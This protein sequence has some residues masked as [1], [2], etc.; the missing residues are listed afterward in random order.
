MPPATSSPQTRTT[1][2]ISTAPTTTR[3]SN[4]VVGADAANDVKD[5]TM[6][7]VDFGIELDNA[8]KITVIKN[9]VLNNKTGGVALFWTQTED[10]AIIDNQI[11]K[12]DGDGI[13]LCNC[14]SGGN[15]IYG[16]LI[17]TN[18]S[19]TTN[20]G[21]T[22]D[23]INIGTPN[24]TVGGTAAGGANV[25]AFN[26]GAGIGL[27]QLSTDTGNALVANSIYSNQGLGIDLG[28]T[29]KPLVNQPGGP[30]VGPNHLQNYPVIKS[31]VASASS[32]T[33]SGTLNSAPDQT[34]TIQFFSSPAADSSGY[35]QGKTYI[36]STT[37]TTGSSGNA[38]I[39]FVSPFDMGGQVLTATA[40][41]QSGDTSEFAK[42][43]A[44]ALPIST[45]TSLQVSPNPSSAGENLTF[46]AIVSAADNS[47]PAGTVTFSVDGQSQTPADSL[48][49]V[50]G[51]DVATLTMSLAAGSHT[52]MAQYNAV[53]GYTGS[54]SKPVT[55]VVQPSGG[56]GGDPINGPTVIS[57]EWIGNRT[58][59]S[60]IVLQFNEALN[61]NIAK[62]AADY[63]I[64]TT[65]LKR[66]FGAGS[67]KIS[68]SGA[69]YDSTTNTVTLHTSKNLSV[70]QRYQLTVMG[71]APRG[72]T[73][74]GGVFLDATTDPQ[75]G[76]NYVAILNQQNYVLDPP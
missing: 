71:I 24:N 56:E 12:N 7:N 63:T 76:T 75:K 74:T 67:K 39:Y 4:N 8:P 50:N 68:V 45:N 58:T 10:D 69:V 48:Q 40:T 44:V 11:I 13:L 70:R 61:P 32:T 73:N 30:N 59:A 49:V 43:L 47:M 55:Q 41:D 6:G 66:A 1:G 57:V 29:G 51:L 42:D 26:I 21:N 60:T 16:N 31:A 19:G 14:G 38:T 17:G 35:G 15:R 54:L 5:E 46:T 27:E 62:I 23:G 65:G 3:L 52:I 34:F 33:I 28:D 18:A 37:V 25:I 2:Y 53:A 9:L 22:G 72:L 36:G 20:L 64:L